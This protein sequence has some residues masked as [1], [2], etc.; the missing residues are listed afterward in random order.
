MLTILRSLDKSAKKNDNILETLRKIY[1][2]IAGKS[3]VSTSTK[4]TTT[5]SNKKGKG[6]E[7]YAGKAAQLSAASIAANTSAM[8]NQLKD[9]QTSVDEEDYSEMNDLIEQLNKI[10][11]D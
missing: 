11:S 5:K 7:I 3:S 10:I 8:M 4:K 6:S 2:E 9:I 1:T